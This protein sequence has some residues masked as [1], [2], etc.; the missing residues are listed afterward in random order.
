MQR[1]RLFASS[2]CIAD[3]VD[4]AAILEG[5]SDFIFELAVFIKQVGVGAA[6]HQEGITG[7]KDAEAAGEPRHSK[8]VGGMVRHAAF[9][10][11]FPDFALAP[12]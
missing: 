6:R 4:R 1:L 5:V 12:M 10:D 3:A 8:I 7:R 11:A 9:A 2:N